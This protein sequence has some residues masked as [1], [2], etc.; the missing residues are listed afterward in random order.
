MAR[1]ERLVGTENAERVL[2]VI[3]N[4]KEGSDLLIWA[5]SENVAAE[6][7][8]KIGVMLGLPI[9]INW[10]ETCLSWFRRASNASQTGVILGVL[11]TVISWRLWTRRCKARMEGKMESGQLCGNLSNS[12]WA[13]SVKAWSKPAQ[14]RVKLNTDGSSLGNPGESGAGGVIRDMHGTLLLAFAKNLGYGNSTYAELRALVEG[15]KHCKNMNFSAVDIE[16][17]SKVILAWLDK[18]RCGSWYLED[19]WEELQLQLINMDIRF[20]HIHREGNAVADWLARRGA[21]D[22]DVEWWSMG[23]VSPLSRGLIIVDKWGLPSIR[24]KNW[25]S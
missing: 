2:E 5:T 22:G 14:G 19:V 3:A 9:G 21:S 10:Y 17:D 8:K 7:W 6:V 20:M 16:M 11:P 12:G 4:C 25:M 24:R 1:L 15:V 13:L 23:E 18:N